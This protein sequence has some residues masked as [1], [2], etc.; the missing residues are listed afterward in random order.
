MENCRVLSAE[1]VHN[2]EGGLRGHVITVLSAAC[3]TALSICGNYA[4]LRYIGPQWLALIAFAPAMPA[5]SSSW[6][7]V[8]SAHEGIPPGPGLLV[9]TLTFALWAAVIHVIRLFRN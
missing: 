5:Y 2:A 8:G 3:L 1:P 6:L 9:F 4:L 7:F